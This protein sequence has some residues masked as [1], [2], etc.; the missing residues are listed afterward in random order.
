M[1]IKQKSD[2]WIIKAV[3]GVVEHLN[4]FGACVT[5]DFL[6]EE[7]GCNILDEVLYLR[8]HESYQVIGNT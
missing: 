4:E 1:Q 8:K 5:D 3:S 6:G 2:N 7:R